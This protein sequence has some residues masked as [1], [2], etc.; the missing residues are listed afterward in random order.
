MRV[1]GITAQIFFLCLLL[2]GAGCESMPA[3]ADNCSDI[4]VYARYAPVK[5]D[6]LPLTEFAIADDDEQENGSEINVYVSLLDSFG[7]QGK[8]PGTFRFELYRKLQRSAEPKGKR[9]VIWPDFD[10]TSPVKNNK[11]WRDFLRAYE[12]NLDF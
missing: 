6:I 3:K 10:L 8:S 1:V 2:V 9:I 12:I 11:H 7:H 4:S 5:V